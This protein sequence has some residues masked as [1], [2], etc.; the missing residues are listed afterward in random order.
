MSPNLANANDDKINAALFSKTQLTPAGV[1]Q[2]NY[3]ENGDV[4]GNYDVF[5]VKDG[6][7]VKE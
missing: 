7:F 4:E 1:I 2:V 3:D 5:V 6:M